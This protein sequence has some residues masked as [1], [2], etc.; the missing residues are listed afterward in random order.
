MNS[1]SVSL[2]LDSESKPDT[3]MNSLN[4]IMIILAPYGS[5]I[6]P[7]LALITMLT[8]AFLEIKVKLESRALQILLNK[9]SRVKRRVLVINFAQILLLLTT[10]QLG[11]VSPE[12][13][14]VSLYILG[15]KCIQTNLEL[16]K[17]DAG[18]LL[19]TWIYVFIVKSSSTVCIIGKYQSSKFNAFESSV[20]DPYH[21]DGSGS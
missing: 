4:L 3:I 19:S 16:V 1:T 9:D 21:F 12:L 18:G 13:Q 17:Q 20:S 6:A 7:T 10:V 14:A 5:L 11:L 8:L 15:V 2:F